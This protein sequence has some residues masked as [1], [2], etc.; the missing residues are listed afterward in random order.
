MESLTNNQDQKQIDTDTCEQDT[1]ETLSVKE[2]VKLIERPL[3]LLQSGFLK[4][5]E[6]SDCLTEISQD[7]I[8]KVMYKLLTY[9]SPEWGIKEIK[10]FE[11]L[12]ADLLTKQDTSAD[13]RLL[14]L[15]IKGLINALESLYPRSTM[16]FVKLID[17]VL[18]YYRREPDCQTQPYLFFRLH[19]A[20]AYAD[21]LSQK[22]IK[23]RLKKYHLFI[24]FEEYSFEKLCKD[25]CVNNDTDTA[26][27]NNEKRENHIYPCFSLL[28][29]LTYSYPIGLYVNEDRK[30]EYFKTLDQ[31]YFNALPGENEN[32]NKKTGGKVLTFEEEKHQ[33]VLVFNKKANIENISL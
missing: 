27:T 3:C 17:P 30:D 6:L 32:I 7:F 23:K 11:D 15:V 1:P 13:L 29:K 9:L 19:K 31:E 24:K 33:S 25:I 14:Q 4:L 10:M 12:L 21:I 8:D 28:R 2:V 5:F 26:D 22:K 20:F 16:K 18:E